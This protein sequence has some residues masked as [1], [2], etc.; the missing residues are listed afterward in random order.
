VRLD[1]KAEGL[2]GQLLAPSEMVT[3]IIKGC[4]SG[5]SIRLMG[6]DQETKIR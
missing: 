3:K 1:S 4:A 6:T 5:Q 2:P